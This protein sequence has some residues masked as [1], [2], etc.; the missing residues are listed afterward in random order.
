VIF[1]RSREN[2]SKKRCDSSLPGKQTALREQVVIHA[3][4]D[5]QTSPFFF[6]FK[7][8]RRFLRDYLRPDIAVDSMPKLAPLWEGFFR[9]APR[10]TLSIQ[11][12]RMS[13]PIKNDRWSVSTEDYAVRVAIPDLR[14]FFDNIPL[15]SALAKPK[16]LVIEPGTR[17]LLVDQG[18]LI[19]EIPA[20]SYTFES[21]TERLQF[22]RDKQ[23][24]AFITRSED[25]AI[26]SQLNKVPC[27]D[28]VCY[29]VKARWMLQMHDVLPFLLNLMGAKE[30]MPL[31]DLVTL[32][33]PIVNQA[34]RT[35]I[36]SLSFDAVRSPN[37]TEVL[38]DSVRDAVSVKLQRYGLKF[39][40]FQA[41][42]VTCDDD[43]HAERRGELW[44]KRREADLT[45]AAHEIENE[46]LN[47]KLE[48]TQAKLGVRDQLRRAV[49]SDEL[50]KLKNR[51]D[52]E[53]A[54]LQIDK[55][56]LLRKE[57]RDIL[58]AAFEERKEDRENL[59][60]HLLATIDLQ[61]EQELAELRIQLDFA[62]RVQALEKEIE[63]T[64]ISQTKDSEAWRYELSKEKE[65]ATH[66]RDLKLES[67]KAALDRAR[68]IRR[69]TRDD[70][71]EKLLFDQRVDL[72]RGDMEISQQERKSRLSLMQ[73]ELN[74]RL[75]HDKL[76]LD[77]RRSEWELEHSQRKSQNQLERLQ[78]VQRMNVEFAE[79]QARM[80]IELENL[81]AD[82]SNK[83]ELDRLV[84]L[85]NLGTDA[86]IA[87]ANTANASLLADLKKHE[88]ST[89]RSAEDSAAALSAK[90]KLEEERLR[91]YDKLNETERAKADAI[92][93]AFKL[94]MQAQSANVNQ[95]I[96]GLAQVATA[97]AKPA[98]P[99]AGQ[100]PPPLAAAAAI[101]WH[102]A[103]NGQS[104]PP[105]QWPQVQQYIQSGQ[106][107]AQTMVWKTGLANWLPAAQIPE[108]ASCFT[109]PPPQAGG[110]PGPPPLG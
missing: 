21:F 100:A 7:P 30:Q 63:L 73:S 93:E 91:M 38:T 70:S 6:F 101:V 39:I 107:T 92:S 36:G 43:G 67:V 53:A 56:R 109:L 68:E 16:T 105:L 46:G 80:Q 49:S 88:M 66:R 27:L 32:V 22:W 45:R 23:V 71:W 50:N 54:I 79:R 25:V 47:V 26:N 15:L 108:L 1:P 72:V 69:Q 18:V 83:R 41:V 11:D 8:R 24:T 104:S 89:K 90:A 42:T 98:S 62:T 85:S 33:Y 99:P 35:T 61:R 3:P 94:A 59:R 40:E 96:G 97:G 4:N 102:I 74:A 65:Q 76:E 103:V 78:Q 86:L 81:K 13:V 77:K 34:I 57:E 31:Q 37:F 2:L 48:D 51:D 20:G 82:S 87:G 106:L 19:G 64:R 28:N 95:M 58:I 14:G 84:T 44:L 5:H 29:D 75:E 9:L 60:Q 17:A 55:G 110:P 52:F 12:S 10:H